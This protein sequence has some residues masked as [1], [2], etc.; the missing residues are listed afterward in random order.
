MNKNTDRMTE[1]YANEL[2]RLIAGLSQKTKNLERQE[3]PLTM[4]Q[5]VSVNNYG[6]LERLSPYKNNM[7]FLEI[8]CVMFTARNIL[9]G[10]H[11]VE[12]GVLGENYTNQI[13][14]VASRV[15]AQ[16]PDFTLFEHVKMST[17]MMYTA[18]VAVLTNLN[19]F[20][21]EFNPVKFSRNP[22]EGYGTGSKKIM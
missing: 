6:D 15:M 17:S 8:L 12:L 2:S 7:A 4:E 10:R 20:P 16:A 11:V 19:I 21:P 5:L 1:L 9:W 14:M 18:C 3:I 13:G 22:L